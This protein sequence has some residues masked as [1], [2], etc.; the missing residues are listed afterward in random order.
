M[1]LLIVIGDRDILTTDANWSGFI[2]YCSEN[3]AC[4]DNGKIPHARIE[5]P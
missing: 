3:G 4:L 5:F 1:A 2:E